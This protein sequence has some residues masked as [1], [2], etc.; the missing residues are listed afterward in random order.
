MPIAPHLRHLYRGPEYEARRARIL[1]R[2]GYTCRH[3]SKPAG[4]IAWVYR[5][6]RPADD[7]GAIMWE[8][9]PADDEPELKF[10]AIQLGVAHLDHDSE[11][12]ADDNLASLC[13]RCHLRHDRG[14]H[15]ATRCTRK[16]QARPLLAIAS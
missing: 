6:G 3:C 8:Y 7:A 4:A 16:D 10:S 5:R 15:K 9:R 13:R 2:D 1:E 12:N 11:N 14:Q